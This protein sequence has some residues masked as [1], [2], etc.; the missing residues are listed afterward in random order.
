M[1][2][3]THRQTGRSLCLLG[4]DCPELVFRPVSV[5]ELLSRQHLP[6]V[7]NLSWST[8]QQRAWAKEAELSLPGLQALPRVS[9]L[10][11]G[12]LREGRGGEWRLTDA[13]GSVRCEVSVMRSGS[14]GG[15]KL[16]CL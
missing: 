7:S 2:R 14:A 6:C 12:Y 15:Q 1:Q 3:E 10:L 13:S 8:N 16:L 11:I 4:L 9:L 5:S